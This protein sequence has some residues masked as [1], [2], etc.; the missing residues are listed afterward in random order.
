MNAQAE[1]MNAMVAELTEMIAGTS[2]SARQK[3][4]QANAV[5][6]RAGH[7]DAAHTHSGTRQSPHLPTT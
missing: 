2:A 6:Q 7:A 5:K 3:T 1:R 4:A